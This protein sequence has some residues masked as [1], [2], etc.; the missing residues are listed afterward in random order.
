MGKGVAD[1]ACRQATLASS[2]LLLGCILQPPS[3]PLGFLVVSW[4]WQ[5]DWRLP[6]LQ[7]LVTEWKENK[8]K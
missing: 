5:V 4:L 2:K 1:E 7:T 6:E 3:V 8:S